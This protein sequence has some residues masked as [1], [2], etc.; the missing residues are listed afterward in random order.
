ML[1]ADYSSK[2]SVYLALGTITARQVLLAVKQ[3]EASSGIADQNTYWLIFELLWRD[4]MRLYLYKHDRQISYLG[5][6]REQRGEESILGD[7][8]MPS[9]MR[10]EGRTGYPM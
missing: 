6:C 4:Y 8:T 9:S 10:G 1:G 3:F 2:L 5:V 7:I